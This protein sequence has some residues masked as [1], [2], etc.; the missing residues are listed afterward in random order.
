MT[1]CKLPWAWSLLVCLATLG[2]TPARAQTLTLAEVEARA[3][4]ERPE[5]AIRRASIDRAHADRNAMIAKVRPTLGARAEVSMA[6][7]GQLVPIDSDGNR[8]YVQGSQSL[9][10]ADPGTF[11]PRPRYL[12]LLA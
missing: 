12:A 2:V 10:D 3:Q 11:A 6:P 1:S 5:L 7:G 9:K 8:Y 4:R